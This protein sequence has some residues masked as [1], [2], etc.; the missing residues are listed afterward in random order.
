VLDELPEIRNCLGSLEKTSF[1]SSADD[2]KGVNL[3]ITSFSFKKKIPQDLSGNG[4]GFVFDCRGLPNPGR[5]EK[6][7]AFTG[8]DPI[9]IDYLEQYE[10]VHRFFGHTREIVVQSLKNYLERGFTNLMV[11]FGCTG[12]QHR[13]V[14]CAERLKKEL[15]GMKG[16]NIELIHTEMD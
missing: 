13:S 8:K 5:E 6:Y 4:G 3:K 10:E 14:Y 15:S 12:G 11:N 9:V 2:R 7:R 1:F 16:V